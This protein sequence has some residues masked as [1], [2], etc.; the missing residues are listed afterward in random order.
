[1]GVGPSI[2]GHPLVGG[3]GSW[4]LAWAWAWALRDGGEKA[5][6]IAALASHPMAHTFFFLTA[7][8]R[9]R[10]GG[11]RL[12]RYMEDESFH[13]LISC[14]QCLWSVREACETFDV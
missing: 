10:E 5:E 14:I 3:G 4:G 9:P 11:K 6:E 8:T 7:W 2:R 12:G 13:F 1:M